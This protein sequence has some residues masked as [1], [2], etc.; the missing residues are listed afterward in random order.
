MLFSFTNPLSNWYDSLPNFNFTCLNKNKKY[1]KR[2]LL[3]K[4]N[5]FKSISILKK[6]YRNFSPDIVHSHY[7]S[8]YGLMGTFL[9]HSPYYVSVWGSD[10][11]T[12]PKHS[13][14]SKYLL[15]RVFRK[16]D[17]IFSTSHIM[18][19]EIGLYTKKKVAVIPFGVDTEIFKPHKRNKTNKIVIGYIKSIE[20]IY[21]IDLLIKAFS[22][23]IKENN[24]LELKIIG[25]GTIKQKMKDL[26][27][28]LKLGNS[29]QFSGWI[30]YDHIALEYQ[31]IDIFV[32]PSRFESFGVS[33]L[34]ASSCGIPVIT[35]NVDRKS[36]V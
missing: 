3:S 1:K 25:D 11:F 19:K 24:Q 34:E 22:V 30:A 28:E 35:T 23:A 15:K 8:S 33:V 10:V 31:N 9:N 5:Y 14:I 29:V 7:A 32:N 21:G 6:T 17:K 13:F 26:V 36:V 12:F 20:K 18:A 2:T 4:I 27:S 16:S